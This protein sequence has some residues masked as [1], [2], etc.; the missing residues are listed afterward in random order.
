MST[1]SSLISAG[2]QEASKSTIQTLNDLVQFLRTT[3]CNESMA[4]KVLLAGSVTVLG[5]A[6]SALGY[7]MYRTYRMNKDVSDSNRLFQQIDFENNLTKSMR[8]AEEIEEIEKRLDE[9]KLSE[10]TL[11]QIMDILD[12]EL[13]RGLNRN[14][15]AE[16]D[17]KMLPT[18]VT[19]LPSGN[20]TNDILALDLGGSNFRVLLIRL[21][22]GEEPKILNK[23]FI[24]SESI[25]KGSGTKLF[26]HIA[27]CLYLFMKNHNLDLS[28]TYPLGFTFSFP[29]H[30]SGLQNAYLLRW[31]K[32]FNCANVVGENVIKLIQHA[33]D[34]RQDIKVK[35]IVLIN[36]TVGTL[37]SC[38]YK[39]RRTAIGLILGTGTNACY[40]ENVQK[41]ETA[42]FDAISEETTEMIVNTE[43]G[44]FGENGCID[45]IRSRYDEEID[46][47]SINMGK[48]I[49]EKMVSG[50]YLGEIVRLIILDLIDQE[51]IFR[52]EMQKN[53]YRHALF[54]KGSFYTKYLNEIESDS[55]VRFSKTKRILKELAG[56]ENPSIQDCAVIKYICNSVTKRAAQLIA[57]G[58]AV[59]LKRMDRSDVTIA[60]DGSLFRYHPRLQII[61]EGTLKNL[62]NPRNK[63]QII[64]STDGSGCGA[65]VVAAV[66]AAND[67][68][69]G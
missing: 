63:F 61:L 30:Q 39:D 23:V 10:E 6:A 43:W 67:T 52:E 27:N 8:P 20:E 55:N 40:I 38:S 35:V 25:M 65:A 5:V 69:L 44:A 11:R 46:K 17:V 19:E 28:K 14:L 1:S 51:L 32:G 13:D 3:G 29:C 24:V 66:A 37:M 33:I 9:F 16:A 53:S 26:N 4:R 59:I 54:T 36:D 31:T 68:L 41:I 49:F 48:Q 7:R 60:V 12:N 21:R 45:F 62:I 18:Y 42:D 34:I 57:S 2:S 64:L 22:K 58:L 56:I 50:M 47:T 15:N